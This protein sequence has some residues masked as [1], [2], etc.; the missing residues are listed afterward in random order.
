MHAVRAINFAV[1]SHVV[2]F[3][4]HYLIAL[5]KSELVGPI[6]QIDLLVDSSAP[7]IRARALN[8]P[9]REFWFQRQ[10]ITGHSHIVD[11]RMFEISFAVR[12]LKNPLRHDDHLSGWAGPVRPV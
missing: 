10:V 1:L 11:L 6:P 12:A 7:A 3:L 4:R 5:R 9:W 2:G 8:P